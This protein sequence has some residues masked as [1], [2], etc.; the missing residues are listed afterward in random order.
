MRCAAFRAEAAIDLCAT[1]S[2][3]SPVQTAARWQWVSFFEDINSRVP[4]QQQQQVAISKGSDNSSRSAFSQA[5]TA[6]GRLRQRQQQQ[7]VVLSKGVF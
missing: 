2:T 7:W 1:S 5:A 6:V 4:R 3:V